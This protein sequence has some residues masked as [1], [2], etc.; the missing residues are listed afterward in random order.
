MQRTGTS[1]V[2]KFFQDFGL[3]WAGWPADETNLWS[4]AW[5]RGDFEVIFN[6]A[7][8][9][10][11]NAFEDSPWFM[12]EF[13]KVLYRRFPNSK[14]VLFIRDQ[15]EWFQSMLNHS[16]GNIIGRSN[17]HCKL[18][19]REIEYLDLLNRN[20]FDVKKENMIHSEKTMK[21]K[22]MSNHYK[23]VY[24]IH[25]SEVQHFFRE[26]APNSLHVGKLEDPMKW[27]KLG[28]FLEI[29]VPHHYE[30]HENRSIAR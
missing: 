15:E 3:Q 22:H 19:R 29:D 11:A 21:L 25:N 27:Q 24:D 5:Y 6:S 7:D 9:Q 8:F 18:Y 10:H 26:Y 28:A 20:N 30:C 4:D 17:I 16:K 2:G 23:S 12:P 13:Y 1:S 14:F